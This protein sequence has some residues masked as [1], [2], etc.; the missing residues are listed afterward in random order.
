[1]VRTEAAVVLGLAPPSLIE[2][3]RSLVSMGLD[4]LRTLELRN[5]LYAGI[6]LSLPPYLLRES[7]SV[8]ELAQAIL[9]A[10]LVQM[11]S[12]ASASHGSASQDDDS[13]QQEVL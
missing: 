7:A 13:Y 9:D 12:P 6:G 5:R 2:A 11:T 3:E 10:M 4:S 1:M 8:T